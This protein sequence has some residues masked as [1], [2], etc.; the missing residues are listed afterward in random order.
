MV[1]NTPASLA[2]LRSAALAE[3]TGSESSTP[4]NDQVPGAYEKLA[5]VLGRDG[6]HGRSRVVARSADERTALDPEFPA[7]ILAQ[8]SDEIAVPRDRRQEGFFHPVFPENIG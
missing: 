1:S 5:F 6:G 4:I 7:Y 2:N 8:P 3:T